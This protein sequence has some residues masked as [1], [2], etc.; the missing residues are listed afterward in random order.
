[1]LLHHKY[2]T[3]IMLM[4]IEMNPGGVV[5]SA[6]RCHPTGPGFDTG[7]LGKVDSGSMSLDGS[8]K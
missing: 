6:F 7:A 8:M 4:K 5:V 3:F 2:R 1:M